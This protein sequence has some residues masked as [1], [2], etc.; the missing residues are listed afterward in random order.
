MSHSHGLIADLQ[1]FAGQREKGVGNRISVGAG[2]SR[3]G[4]HPG[5]G[6]P[7]GGTP[8]QR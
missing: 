1:Y 6:G 2:V 5:A 4:R 3:P 7:P 8:P